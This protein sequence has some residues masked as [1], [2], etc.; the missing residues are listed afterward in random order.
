RARAAAS[1]RATSAYGFR[2]RLRQARFQYRD[3]RLLSSLGYP[4][5]NLPK[6]PAHC[7]QRTFHRP[8]Q[9]LRRGDILTSRYQLGDDFT[10]LTM[11]ASASAMCRLARSWCRASFTV[12]RSGAAVSEL[13]FDGGNAPARCPVSCFPEETRSLGEL[14]TPLAPSHRRLERRPTFGRSSAALQFA[15][16]CQR[17]TG[18]ISPVDRR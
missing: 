17:Y 5:F 1:S 3:S 8:E 2:A 11:R 14:P 12:S 16:R 15:C 6:M 7:V 4:G 13:Q 10:C 9:V 18:P